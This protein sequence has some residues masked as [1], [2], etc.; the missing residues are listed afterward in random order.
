M[1]SSSEQND[2][3]YEQGNIID[4]Y[5]V[6]CNKPEHNIISSRQPFDDLKLFNKV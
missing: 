1:I 4:D 6:D 3:L 5:Q 2:Y